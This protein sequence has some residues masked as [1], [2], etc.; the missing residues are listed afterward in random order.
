MKRS[1]EYMRNLEIDVLA[2][3]LWGEARGEG[4]VGMQAVA[5]V[6][7]NRRALALDG[8]PDWW[9]RDIIGICQKPFQFS[10]WNRTDPNF[11]KVSRVDAADADFA[12]ALRIARRVLT[13]PADDITGGATHYHARGFIPYWAEGRASCA[14]IGDHLF[15]RLED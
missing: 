10:C 7:L 3:T 1:A 12:C 4:P 8:G 11:K 9:G 2:R 14:T 15:Y 13:E 6:V 5:C